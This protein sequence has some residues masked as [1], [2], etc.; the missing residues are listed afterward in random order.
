MTSVS[1][2]ITEHLDIWTSAIETKSGAGRGH[3]GAVSLYGIKK[4]RELILE[5]AVQG[6]LVPQLGTEITALELM[7]EHARERL[8]GLQEKHFKKQNLG[9][10]LSNDECPFEIPSSWCWSRLGEIGFI[11]NGNSISSRDKS[12]KYSSPGG[13]PFLATKNI[14]YGFQPI[15]YDVDAWIPLK[16]PKFKTAPSDTVLICSE[17]GSAGK[18]CG[19][20]DHEV[21]FGNKLFA[22]QFYGDF[23]S[24]YLLSY[25]QTPSFY[26]QFSSKM[27]GIIGGISL[28]KFLRLPVP[29]PP[30]DEQRRIVAKVVELMELCDVLEAR[31]EDS[32]NAHKTLVETCLATLTNS[33]TPDE[34]TQNWAR[35]EENFDTLFTTTESIEILKN[36]VLELSFA[37]FVNIVGGPEGAPTKSLFTKNK[38]GHM[39]QE[40]SGIS[41]GVIKLGTEPE[42]GGIPTL[43]C[44]DVKPGY[45]IR[46]TVRSVSQ[47]IEK[48]YL[49]TRLKGGEVVL[50][51]RG[52]LGGVAKVPLDM[53][54]FNV[55]REVAVIP[56]GN[57]IMAEYLVYF[58]RSPT[59]WAYLEKNLRGIAYKGLNLGILRELEIP[60]PKKEIQIQ[61]V[62][63]IDAIFRIC[64]SINDA[65]EKSNRAE[66]G[67]ADALTRGF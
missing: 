59:F 41:Y 63:S 53:K 7:K 11:F 64:D 19:L 60:V 26:S 4:L 5:L 34:L 49:R 67:L 57:K 36:S 22:C 8:I 40:G 56:V 46:S 24:K 30:L 47:E 18:K 12:A 35:I 17:G 6:K 21:C 33:Q 28:A 2:Y 14:G 65:Q 54:D 51:I 50:N 25:Y 58:L 38:L 52:T 32:R 62:R 1:H 66:I 42:S 43:R 44:S 27:T 39:L 16:E 20:T 13:L 45:I 61:L 3:G 9:D 15:D 23:A 10:V 55:A 37:G 31:T 48:E 29:I